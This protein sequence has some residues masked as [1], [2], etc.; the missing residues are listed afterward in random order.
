RACLVLSGPALV[1]LYALQ[2]SSEAEGVVTSRPAHI[3]AAGKEIQRICSRVVPVRHHDSR[4]G[5]RTHASPDRDLAGNSP[6]DEH[7]VRRD[8]HGG[9]CYDWRIRSSEATVQAIQKVRREDMGLL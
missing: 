3:I 5:R 1:F 8:W 2:P 7:K 6:R 9:R 4:S